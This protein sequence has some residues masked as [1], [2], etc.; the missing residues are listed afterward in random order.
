MKMIIG[1]W[2]MNPVTVVEGEK[3]I[4]FVQKTLA[5]FKYTKVAVCP[6]SL[7]VGMLQKNLSKGKLIYGAQNCSAEDTG[8]FTGQVSPASLK[9]VGVTMVILGHSESR[10][11][12]DTPELVG[13][14]VVAVLRNGITPV[15]CVGERVRDDAGAFFAEVESQLRS[16]LKAVPRTDGGRIIIAYEPVWA[17]GAR[18]SRPATPE[19]LQEMIIYIR[20]TLVS[21]FGRETAFLI[22]I[23]YGGSADATNAEAFLTRGGA[24]GLLVGRASLD[25]KLFAQMLAIAEQIGVS[26]NPLQKKGKTSSRLETGKADRETKKHRPR[27]PVPPKN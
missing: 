20:K 17:I 16:A 21:L 27:H 1:N 15:V 25:A 11:S 7:H 23:L 12:G 14:K 3:I 2:K 26:A 4:K 13:H 8:S 22:P 19:D 10:I 18:A 5:S 6:Q 9:K 24:D